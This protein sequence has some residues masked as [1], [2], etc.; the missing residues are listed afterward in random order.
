MIHSLCV[1]LTW[2]DAVATGL[3]DD[4]LGDD[5]RLGQRGAV[6]HFER[7]DFALGV[8]FLVPLLLLLPIEQ[9]NV[10]GL[11]LGLGEVDRHLWST[12]LVCHFL[13]SNLIPDTDG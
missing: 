13:C 12:K 2:I 4:V 5:C 8:D 7:G 9:I 6:V 1:Y 11:A 3:A 10:L